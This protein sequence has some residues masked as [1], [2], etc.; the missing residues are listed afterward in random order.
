MSLYLFVIAF[1]FVSRA[2]FGSRRIFAKKPAAIMYYNE[3]ADATEMVLNVIMASVA[4]AVYVGYTNN[5]L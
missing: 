4:V 1:I 5:M 2:W 3:K